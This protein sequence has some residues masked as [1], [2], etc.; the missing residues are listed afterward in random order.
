MEL[1]Q[2]Y[3]VSSPFTVVLNLA[4][5]EQAAAPQ[6]VSHAQ[7]GGNLL[8]PETLARQSFFLFEPDRCSCSMLPKPTKLSHN[9]PQIAVRNMPRGQAVPKSVWE[10]CHQA[11]AL[12]FR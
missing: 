5:G 6:H 1:P 10:G 9:S 8:W 7:L 11:R 12:Q 4:D 3:T 2:R